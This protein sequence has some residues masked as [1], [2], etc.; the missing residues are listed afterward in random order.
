MPLEISIQI[1]KKDSFLMIL[2]GDIDSCTS[3]NLEKANYKIFSTDPE[4]LLIDMAG[5][6]FISS[7]GI[8][9][10]FDLQR[11]VEDKGGIVSLIGVKPRVRKVLEFV[12]VF[13]LER[14]FLTMEDADAYLQRYMKDSTD[15]DGLDP[16]EDDEEL[17]A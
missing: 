11:R 6:D 9:V 5:V 15:N 2:K 17:G 1:R 14:M 4:R 7:S 16:G 13:P 3:V 12:K 8:R 10:L